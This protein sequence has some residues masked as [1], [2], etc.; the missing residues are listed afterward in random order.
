[1]AFG[2]SRLLTPA[3]ERQVVE[4]RH[5]LG[6][7]RDLLVPLPAAAPDLDALGAAVRQLDELFMIVVAGEFNAGK[8]A[9]VNALLGTRVFDE[10]V[11][12]TTARIQRVRYGVEVATSD[13][14][15]GVV[16]TAPVELLR[17]LQIV[18]TPGT[19]AIQREHERL[20]RE[21]LPR[22]D[23][24][25]FV[26]SADRP[27]T[28]SE[29]TFL[30]SIR[31]WGKKIVLVVNKVDIFEQEREQTAVMA[32]VRDAARTLLGSEPQL[33]A[34]SARRAWHA[35]HGD[36]DQWSASGFAELEAFLRDTLDDEARSR[37]KLASPI[38]V[39]ESLAR[40]YEALAGDRLALLSADTEALDD[41][42]RQL[43]LYDEDLGRGFDL[44]MSAVE[45]VLAEMESR[46]HAFLDDTLRIG[47][48]F[49]LMNR[50]RI[51]Q[52]FEARVVADAPALVEQRVTELIDWLVDQDL[53]QWQALSARLAERRREHGDRILGGD[54]AGTFQTHRAA[55]IDSVGRQAQRVV[56][57]FDRRREAAALADGARTA[58]AASAAMGA[59]AL[60][61]GAIV[62]AVA[63]TA[64]AD[65]SGLL[66]AS[67]LGAVGLLILP[68][69]RRRA[70]AEL[71]AKI[72]DLRQRLAQA[73]R[74]EFATAR[75]RSAQRLTDSIAPYSRFVRAEQAKWTDA[76]AALDTWRAKASALLS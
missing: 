34:V 9:L 2:S 8:S 70:R 14:G 58:V 31:E 1:M 64:A 55:L 46:G 44:R 13:D 12:P 45:R 24:V 21:F 52:E 18:D 47:R 42:T 72:G 71:Q 59:S 33:F 30:D 15:R 51:Q 3:V 66:A 35:K 16:V 62:T 68:A 37:L 69:K 40:R 41:T 27:F 43:A 65:V 22:A 4:V 54:D 75:G 48:V 38:G 67:V 50:P 26:T 53:R 28:E 19:N 61:L 32:F 5:L 7:I 57:T 60:G 10:G 20:T 73:L 49:D 6:D 29:R 63:T 76:R 74:G 39:G 25:L 17:D 11:T 36:P 56:E 23:L